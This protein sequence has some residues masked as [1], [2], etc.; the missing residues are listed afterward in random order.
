MIA[1]ELYHWNNL[2]SRHLR[3]LKQYIQVLHC[4]FKV[5]TSLIFFCEEAMASIL[6][7]D[8]DLCDISNHPRYH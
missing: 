1:L 8:V 5:N 3:L 4:I 2:P 6:Y 7:L